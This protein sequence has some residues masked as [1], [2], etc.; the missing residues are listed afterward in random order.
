MANY[1]INQKNELI[2][3]SGDILDYLTGMYM[4]RYRDGILA[5][6]GDSYR[7]ERFS[8]KHILS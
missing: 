6:S 1:I 2:G 5:Q 7:L 3:R 8:Y 4:D